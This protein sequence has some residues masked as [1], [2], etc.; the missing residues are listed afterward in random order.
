MEQRVTS[1]AYQELS[2]EAKSYLETIVD[3]YSRI[4]DRDRDLI[5]MTVMSQAREAEM[6]LAGAVPKSSSVYTNS[7]YTTGRR[8]LRTSRPTRNTP[9]RESRFPSR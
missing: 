6:R 5:A 4:V 7:D 1:L 2:D 9:A 3:D 8:L